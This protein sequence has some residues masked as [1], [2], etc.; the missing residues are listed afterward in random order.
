MYEQV[1]PII[2]ELAVLLASKQEGTPIQPDEVKWFY[3]N[4]LIARNTLTE[5][6]KDEEFQKNPNVPLDIS[7]LYNKR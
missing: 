5:L 4:Y 7:R 6:E 3:S 1:N 2:H